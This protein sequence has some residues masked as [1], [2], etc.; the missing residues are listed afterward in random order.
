M[1]SE[2]PLFS[3]LVANYNNGRYLREALDSVWQQTYNNWQVVVVD[4]GSTDE[5]H[6]IYKELTSDPRFK[7]VLN[8]KNKGC[9]FTKKRCIDE[10]EGELC[11]FLDADDALMPN[12][13]EIMVKTHEEKQHSS[14]VISRHFDCDAQMNVLGESRLLELQ[15]GESYL[16]HADYQPE[17]FVSFK[18]EK[19]NLTQGLNPG[20]Q[21]GD[22]QELLILLEEVGDFV[23]LNAITYKYRHQSDSMI[24]KRSDECIYWNARVFHE[25]CL[26]RGI[27]PQIAVN[28]YLNYLKSARGEA[29]WLSEERTTQK[30]YSSK[31]YRL[32][33]SL[34]KP[35]SI[36]KREPR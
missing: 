32:G 4:D 33:K 22:D 34:L 36:F 5:S 35:L 19:Y 28:Y 18:K 21:I 20:N 13:L 2:H 27:D 24:H 17:H 11:G 30:I 29:E 8:D 23:V 12:A 9:T 15:K 7:V 31:A 25:A 3:V 14:V 6:D 16:E 10:A 1:I 26:R